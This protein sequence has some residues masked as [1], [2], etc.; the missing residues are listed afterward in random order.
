[1]NEKDL[2]NYYPFSKF[3]K[4]YLISNPSL[5]ELRTLTKK[6]LE[7][8]KGFSLENENG[9]IIFNDNVDLTGVNLNC[10]VL[11]YM[12]FAIINVDNLSFEKINKS[13]KVYLNINEDFEDDDKFFTFCSQL[14]KKYQNRNVTCL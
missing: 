1:M 3:D 4:K 12:N 13:C 6:Q 2:E 14:E 8:I 9:K 10:I 7:A 5:E 11:D